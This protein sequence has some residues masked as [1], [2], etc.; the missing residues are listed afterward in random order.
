MQ[1]KQIVI[2]QLDISITSAG[3]MPYRRAILSTTM[4]SSASFAKRGNRIHVL[5]VS[6]MSLDSCR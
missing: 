2:S 5:R 4:A 1:I 6:A 3:L